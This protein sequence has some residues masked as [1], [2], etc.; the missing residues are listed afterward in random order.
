MSKRPVRITK[1]PQIHSAQRIS[2]P[3]LP[4][5]GTNFVAPR[6]ESSKKAA[7]R[8]AKPRRQSA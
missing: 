4:H 6:P 7:K 8:T 1:V 5:N 2:K 3:G